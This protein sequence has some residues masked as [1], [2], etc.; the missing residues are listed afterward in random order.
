MIQK[1][2]GAVGVVAVGAYL[3]N[4]KKSSYNSA[5]RNYERTYA[6]A[7]DEIDSAFDN[8]QF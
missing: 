3:L 8:Q 7:K 2:L 4:G 1:L 6:D 5:V